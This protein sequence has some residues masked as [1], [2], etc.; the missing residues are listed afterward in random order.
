[1]TMIN[2]MT[3]DG[4]DAVIEFDSDIRMFRGEFV[5][6]NGG[7][8]FYAESVAGLEKEGHRSLKVFLDMCRERGIEPRKSFSGKFVV[9]VPPKL[10][11]RATETAAARRISLNELVKAALERETADG[12]A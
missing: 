3:I 2:T 11:E 4:F 7:A 12:M 9:R 5:G 1:M 8:D 10:H 6:L